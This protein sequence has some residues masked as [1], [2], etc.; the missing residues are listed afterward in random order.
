MTT[1]TLAPYTAVASFSGAAVD[2][3]T[4]TYGISNYVP[5]AQ[6]PKRGDAL[7]IFAGTNTQ[8]NP[9]VAMTDTPG[10]QWT[11][12][13]A[14]P[15]NVAQRIVSWFGIAP[16]DFLSTDTINGQWTSAGNSKTLV[17]MGCAGL[18]GELLHGATA[19]GATQTQFTSGQGGPVAAPAL[20]AGFVQSA[21]AGGGPTGLS[22]GDST[23]RQW[24]AG[25]GPWVTAVTEQIAANR[26]AVELTGTITGSQAVS[27]LAFG[28]GAIVPG[29]PLRVW[30][31][32]N[33]QE[34]NANG[35]RVWD[36]SDWVMTA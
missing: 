9:P 2:N 7:W 34:I 25:T 22:F 23:K 27:A 5:G 19:Y 16:R 32:S 8:G 3:F 1:P 17:V 10:T 15:A 33:W 11:P 29:K 4:L 21:A 18:D 13:P 6:L 14:G 36:G 28:L 20:L 12:G 26:A 24:Q 35:A 30:T 31:G